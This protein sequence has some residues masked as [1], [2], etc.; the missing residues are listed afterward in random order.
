VLRCFWKKLGLA[1][2]ADVKALAQP[3][4]ELKIRLEDAGINITPAPA[5]VPHLFAL[6]Q[7]D[8]RDAFEYAGLRYMEFSRV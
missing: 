5:G 3:L 2:S 4:K 7:D 1:A 8:I 6:H